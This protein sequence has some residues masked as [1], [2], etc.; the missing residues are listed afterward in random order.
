MLFPPSVLNQV[1]YSL[2]V[3]FLMNSCS[4][5]YREGCSSLKQCSPSCSLASPRFRLHPRWCPSGPSTTRSQR[6]RSLSSSPPPLPRYRWGSRSQGWLVSR[7]E[8]GFSPPVPY[9]RSAPACTRWRGW[10]MGKRAL[11]LRVRRVTGLGTVIAWYLGTSRCRLRLL[12]CCG[13][14]ASPWNLALIS[15]LVLKNWIV[16]D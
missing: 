6:C 15:V 13:W 9:P 2:A 8:L 1:D 10:G 5:S 3:A 12:F 16:F 7:W 4:D 11:G 14:A